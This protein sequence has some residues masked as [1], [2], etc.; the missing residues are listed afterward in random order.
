M[1]D[2]EY[3]IMAVLCENLGARLSVSAIAEETGL[4]KDAIIDTIKRLSANRLV[5]SWDGKY[6][7]SR[8]NGLIAFEAERKTRLEQAERLK[9]DAKVVR[10]Q[11]AE[12]K[13]DR[14]FDFLKLLLGGA[15]A[16]FVEHFS[17]ITG[18][19]IKLFS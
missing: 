11:R 16:L 14:I 1:T 4:G 10:D 19:F 17:E 7:V 5:S 18:W 15:V 6:G 9:Y 12:K 8:P 3:Q 2:L 13:Q